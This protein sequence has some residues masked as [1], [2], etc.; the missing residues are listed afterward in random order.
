MTGFEYQMILYS[1]ISAQYDCK[2]ACALYHRAGEV[3]IF[4]LRHIKFSLIIPLSISRT[5][6]AP[7]LSVRPKAEFIFSI[8]RKNAMQKTA[9]SRFISFALVLVFLSFL[10][11]AHSTGMIGVTAL[12]NGSGCDCHSQSAST[13]VTI[14]GP[15]T[16]AKGAT[17]TYTVTITGGPLKAAGVDIAASSGKLAVNASET[18]LQYMQ[19]ELTHKQPKT[20]TNSKVVFTFDLTA[21]GTASTIT[22]YAAGNSV[23]LSNDE[24]GDAWNFAPNKTV[25]ITAASDVKSDLA[26]Y[27]FALEQNYPNPFNPSTTIRYSVAGTSGSASGQIVSLKV[28]SLKGE[29]VRTLVQGFQSTGEHVVSFNAND[30][31][32][33]IYYYTMKMG[34]ESVTKKMLLLK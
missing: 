2:P 20:P 16:L 7:G 10:L 14:A 33:G 4:S 22:L 18:F 27:G 8:R 12:T 5:A 9:T 31:P 11:T 30:L 19:G 25:T 15:A 29:E 34:T 21:S 13:Q 23:N 26:R 3:R 28:Y 24:G 32:S 6:V 17:G 1:H